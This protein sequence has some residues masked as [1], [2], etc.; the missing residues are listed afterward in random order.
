VPQAISLIVPA[1]NWGFICAIL[2]ATSCLAGCVPNWPVVSEQGD[3]V[4]GDPKLNDLLHRI[5][6]MRDESALASRN[7][8]EAVFVASVQPTTPNAA[9]FHGI[10]P[11]TDKAVAAHYYLISSGETLDEAPVAVVTKFLLIRRKGA[12][13]TYTYSVLLLWR[14]NRWE[15]WPIRWSWGVIPPNQSP[16]SPGAT[17]PTSKPALR[18]VFP[19]AK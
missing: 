19:A 17:K 14:K 4:G 8:I 5:K 18:R 13:Q 3:I 1:A 10:L 15:E 11:P 7:V 9:S 16:V 2:V 6:D 12:P